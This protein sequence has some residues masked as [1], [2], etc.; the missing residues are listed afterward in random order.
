MRVC[1]CVCVRMSDILFVGLVSLLCVLL[2][3][4]SIDQNVDNVSLIINAILASFLLTDNYFVA[5]NV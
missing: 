2:H 1:V 5:N 4:T 3:S